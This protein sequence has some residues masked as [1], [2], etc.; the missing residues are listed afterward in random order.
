MLVFN[1]MYGMDFLWTAMQLEKK[2]REPKPG[3]AAPDTSSEFN[4]RAM[5]LTISIVA[6]VGFPFLIPEIKE[7]STTI[8]S[9]LLYAG[10]LG[11]ILSSIPLAVGAYLLACK[12]R[13]P[14]DSRNTKLLPETQKI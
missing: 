8:E 6:I 14:T 5:F 10:D 12:P 11:W 3:V 1:A 9:F 13:F 4:G 2:Y 7:K